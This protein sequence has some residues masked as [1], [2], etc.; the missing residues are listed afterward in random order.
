MKII[1][2]ANCQGEALKKIFDKIFKNFNIIYLSNYNYIEG[3]KPIDFNIF[4]D[5]NLFIYQPIKK[6]RGIHSTD[7]I[8]SR[9]NKTI[10]KISFPYIYNVG[11]WSLIINNNNLKNGFNNNYIDINLNS[12]IFGF[13]YLKGYKYKDL[14]EGKINFKL[15]KRFFESIDRLKITEERTDIKIS[16]FIT[17]NYKDIQMFY[18]DCHPSLELIKEVFKRI[19]L[20]TDFKYCDNDLNII[21]D[22]NDFKMLTGGYIPI[23]PIERRELELNFKINNFFIEENNNWR[24]YYYKII[25]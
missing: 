6:E 3:N 13:E 25:K 17:K 4:N 20:K 24:N 15:K 19:I 14:I 22:L 11:M 21:N 5:C 9:L 12:R 10:K 16:D 2:Y 23:T 7:Y 1:I 8:L 18:R